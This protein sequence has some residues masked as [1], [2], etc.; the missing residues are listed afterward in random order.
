MLLPVVIRTH[1]EH[2]LV[3]TENYGR[4]S[5][6]RWLIFFHTVV[7]KQS[8]TNIIGNILIQNPFDSS[9]KSSDMPMVSLSVA[10]I[11]R[12]VY[13][14]KSIGSYRDHKADIIVTIEMTDKQYF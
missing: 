10:L 12:V 14:I 2:T 13:H 4:F 9:E 3:M 5:P 6:P 1:T 8:R 11:N 7:S